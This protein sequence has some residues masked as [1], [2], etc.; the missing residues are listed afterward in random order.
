[1]R[2]YTG[3][4]VGTLP[5]LWDIAIEKLNSNKEVMSLE[6]LEKLPKPY[7]ETCTST[8]G[9]HRKGCPKYK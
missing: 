9:R 3:Q 7:C 8:M 1:V 6:D 2:A 4:K 5:E